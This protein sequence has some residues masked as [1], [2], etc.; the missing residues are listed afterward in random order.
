MRI[1]L[2]LVFSLLILTATAK[3]A[4][5]SSVSLDGDWHFLADPSGTLDGQKLASA[6]KV[7]PTRIPSSWQSQFDD[8][9]DYAGVAWY[10]RTIAVDPPAA[11]QVALLRFG[12]VDYAAQVFV[13]GQKAGS[14]EGG[15]LP[16][17]IEVTSLLHMGE[18]QV[19][20]RVGDPGAK[21]HDLVEGINYAE[22][23]HGK[24]SWYVQNSGLW[25]SV[26]LD[27]R[28]RARLGSVDISAGLDGAISISAPVAGP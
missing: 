10:W 3:P 22:I 14:H 13:N 23:P 28:P 4:A 26:E 1:T 8:L 21:P 2:C 17:E 5:V 27:Y 9:R 6:P 24:Q 12:A 25:Q 18:N 16:F 7:R 19:A 20:V 11:D 15:Y